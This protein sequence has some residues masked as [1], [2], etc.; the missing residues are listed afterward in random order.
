ML[1]VKSCDYWLLDSVVVSGGD[2]PAAV[3][4]DGRFRF[5]KTNSFVVLT[6]KLQMNSDV[7]SLLLNGVQAFQ[8][9]QESLAQSSVMSGLS[10]FQSVFLFSENTSQI[11][12]VTDSCSFSD[13]ISSVSIAIE[14]LNAAV[15]LLKSQ[16]ASVRVVVDAQFLDMT[17]STSPAIQSS[18][19]ALC[20]K[21]KSLSQ[22]L[23]AILSERAALRER[24]VHFSKLHLESTRVPAGSLRVR[25]KNPKSSSNPSAPP[26]VQLLDTRPTP[27]PLIE[28]QMA[29]GS[30]VNAAANP[31]K[32][33]LFQATALSVNQRN[34]VP[35]LLEALIQGKPEQQLRAM[36]IVRSLSDGRSNQNFLVN[37]G[38]A[39][40]IGQLGVKAHNPAVIKSLVAL[41]QD[42][43]DAV[44]AARSQGV[45][46]SVAHILSSL[47]QANSASLPEIADL[48]SIFE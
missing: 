24:H 16:I 15:D 35:Y 17:S 19:S 13:I 36:E 18:I 9:D 32:P 33:R 45:A 40:V 37:S 2:L 22:Q 47:P 28:H 38:F 5:S 7:S 12:D 10:S 44:Q 29:R 26:S 6:P 48:K 21:E 39:K 23:S 34:L 31:A 46:D 11:F 25:T 8:S 20:F 27:Q 14:S 42:N 1:G 43:P 3:H 4:F 30:A 41:L